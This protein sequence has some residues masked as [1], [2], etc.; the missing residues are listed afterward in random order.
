MF[1]DREYVGSLL[2]TILIGKIVPTGDDSYV[3]VLSYLERRWVASHVLSAG[4]F[5]TLF[6]LVDYS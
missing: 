6:A 3:R 5:R 4:V 1:F 2:M